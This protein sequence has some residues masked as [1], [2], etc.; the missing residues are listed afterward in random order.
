MEEAP[1][2]TEHLMVHG[3]A[4]ERM[5]EAE[6]VG[7]ELGEEV[8]IHERPERVDELPLG[9]LRDRGEHVER[10]RRSEHGRGLD[11][12]TLDR[13]DSGEALLDRFLERPRQPG[14][15]DLLRRD[16]AAAPGE[17]LDQE[18]VA[19]AALIRRL[20]QRRRRR[21]SEHGTEDGADTCAVETVETDLF[22]RLAPLEPE[23]QL[24]SGGP[25]AQ[26]L[27]PVRADEH[28][29]GPGLLGEPIDHGRAVGIGPM[30][31]LHDHDRPALT[32]ALDQL[33]QEVG[34]GGLRQVAPAEY[35]TDQR[36]GDT[37]A[38]G[39]GPA[40]EHYDVVRPLGEEL[41]EQAGLAD[42]GFTGD[43]DDRRYVGG[44]HVGRLDQIP[45]GLECGAPPDHD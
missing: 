42:A 14:G 17:L 13:R 8:A 43:K 6:L 19:A 15:G 7:M 29:A 23:E 27:R 39:L 1:L 30:E 3:V 2:A 38:T 4:N 37:F 44:R 45:Q 5:A 20:D 11:H 26:I 32:D 21:R 16:V 24:T 22:D 12:P 35:G 33:S 9:Q 10:G 36:M 28:H 31:I 25:P 34:G 41:L 40:G 18:R